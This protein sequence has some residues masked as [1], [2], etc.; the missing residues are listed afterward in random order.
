MVSINPADKSGRLIAWPVVLIILAIAQH[1]I[2]W[3]YAMQN[4]TEV[5]T[6]I[7][8][9]VALILF[10]SHRYVTPERNVALKV[11]LTKIEYLEALRFRY[12]MPAKN[13][14]GVAS[15]LVTIWCAA[16]GSWLP[17]AILSP[18]KTAVMWVVYLIVSILH[19]RNGLISMKEAKSL[20]KSVPDNFKLENVGL[21]E[22][23]TMIADDATSNKQVWVRKILAV[24]GDKI[25]SSERASG[26]DAWDLK[27]TNAP[28]HRQAKE[29]TGEAVGQV[30]RITL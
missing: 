16:L 28:G 19:L 13:C 5:A 24:Q 29:E 18:F 4:K 26:K 3:Q 15:A 8:V 9:P 12:V 25:E 11:A 20:A 21:G 2:G 6:G 23:W 22:D 7:L 1:F 30:L 27:I 10:C 17:N 14:I